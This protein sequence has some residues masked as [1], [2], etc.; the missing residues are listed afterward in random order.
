M[1]TWL[2]TIILVAAIVVVI[3]AIAALVNQHR[4]E[5]VDLGERFGPEYDRVMGNADDRDERTDAPAELANR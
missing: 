3:A 2:L 4:R 5:T 1:D